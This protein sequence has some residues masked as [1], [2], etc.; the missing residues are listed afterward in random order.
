MASGREDCDHLAKLDMI[1]STG[2]TRIVNA[3]GASSGIGFSNDRIFK[4]TE[5]NKSSMRA[6]GE[7]QASKVQE[8]STILQKSPAKKIEEPPTPD[9]SL[10][11]YLQHMVPLSATSRLLSPTQANLL[12]AYHKEDPIEISYKNV[13]PLPSE[14]H[15]LSP[16]TASKQ[17]VYQPPPPHKTARPTSPTAIVPVSDRLTAFNTARKAGIYEKK[18]VETD[19]RE[20]GWDGSL[21][22]AHLPSEPET[23]EK[24]KRYRDV[25]S[26]LLTPTT[27]S[28]H[29]QWTASSSS[30]PCK[31]APDVVIPTRATSPPSDAQPSGASK[32]KGKVGAENFS[33]RDST[34]RSV[35]ASSPSKGPLNNVGSRLHN[36]TSASK[37]GRY[38]SPAEREPPKSAP[39]ARLTSSPAVS[40]KTTTAQRSSQRAKYVPVQDAADVGG[41]AGKGRVRASSAPTKRKSASRGD[42]SVTSAVTTE[43]DSMSFDTEGHIDLDIKPLRDREVMGLREQVAMLQS[44]LEEARQTATQQS[45]RLGACEAALSLSEAVQLET[46]RLLQLQYRLVAEQA[47]E[48][49]RQERGLSLSEAVQLETT[50]LLQLHYRMVADATLQSKG[51]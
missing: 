18:V 51:S 44:N 35:R 41:A 23:P 9:K 49:K 20:E 14:S 30:S 38:Q 43:R 1:S 16:T 21:K 37:H 29:G 24:S 10:E 50:R 22:S 2:P 34:G 25:R 33:A 42:E 12:G 28:K 19:P 26:K 4:Q 46:T 17:C 13:Q 3:D 6:L 7:R 15:L 27:A 45:A 11:D 8:N 32:G 40:G 5:S 48:L 39:A 47:E 36:P 31:A